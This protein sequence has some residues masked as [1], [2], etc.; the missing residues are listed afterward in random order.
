MGWE[1]LENAFYELPDESTTRNII[2]IV[3]YCGQTEYIIR[4][5]F[6]HLYLNR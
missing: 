3:S 2:L 1:S 6:D 4:S 5:G